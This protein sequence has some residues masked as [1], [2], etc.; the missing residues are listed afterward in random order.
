MLRHTQRNTQLE[1]SL[2]FLLLR[3]EL[4]ED[5]RF[6][7]PWMWMEDVDTDVKQYVH[8]RADL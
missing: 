3:A 7:H 2:Y 8:M 1:M 4:N 5:E 6:Y